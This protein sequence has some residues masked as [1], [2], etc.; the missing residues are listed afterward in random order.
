MTLALSQDEV[1]NHTWIIQ[2]IIVKYHE[3]A[4]E[5]SNVDFE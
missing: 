3:Q 2:K 1:V 4:G 5:K